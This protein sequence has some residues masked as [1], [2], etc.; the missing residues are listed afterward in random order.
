MDDINL[1]LFTKSLLLQ[2]AR[3]AEYSDCIFSGVLHITYESSEYGTKQSDGETPVM[4]E[5]RRMWN[6]PSLPSF[7]GQQKT[8]VV[9]PHRVLPMGQIELFGM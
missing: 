4:I 5:H 9:A 3:A 8:G 6:K 1:P 7:P 2:S